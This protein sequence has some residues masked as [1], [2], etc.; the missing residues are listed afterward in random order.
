M[1]LVNAEFQL[2]MN[3]YKKCNMIVYVNQNIIN[4]P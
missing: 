1:E 4:V 3:I 2:R